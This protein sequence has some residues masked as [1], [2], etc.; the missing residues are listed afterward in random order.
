MAMKSYS[1]FSKLH[2]WSLTIRYSLMDMI[3]YDFVQTKKTE[4]TTEKI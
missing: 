2:D 4:E 3:Q 1:T